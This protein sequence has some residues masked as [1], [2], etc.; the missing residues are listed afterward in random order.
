MWRRFLLWGGLGWM[1]MATGQPIL[2]AA[3]VISLGHAAERFIEGV[4]K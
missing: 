2:Q 3:G 4:G 1:L